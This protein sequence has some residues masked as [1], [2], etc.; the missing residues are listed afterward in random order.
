MIGG[1][2]VN[3]SLCSQNISGLWFDVKEETI[4]PIMIELVV[5]LNHLGV[6]YF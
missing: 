3:C 1:R 5:I 2:V 4:L 6:V